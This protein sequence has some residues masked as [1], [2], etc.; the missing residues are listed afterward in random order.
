MIGHD[1]HDLSYTNHYSNPV[2][3]ILSEERRSFNELSTIK[4]ANQPRR[5]LHR[6]AH[7]GRIEHFS[8]EQHLLSAAGWPIK[9]IETRSRAIGTI[10]RHA[11]LNAFLNSRKNKKFIMPF[12]RG[13][14]MCFI[15]H[16][17][18]PFGSI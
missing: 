5:V 16:F 12:D 14:R 15:V 3:G 9:S 10:I 1:S 7:S 18:Y 4:R 8:F 2:I 6:V 17:R 11:L 13:K